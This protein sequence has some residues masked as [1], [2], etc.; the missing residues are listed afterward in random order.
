MSAVS[1]RARQTTL[2]IARF[3]RATGT[4]VPF[5]HPK[6]AFCIERSEQLFIRRLFAN[7]SY[8]VQMSD[9]LP[10]RNAVKRPLACSQFPCHG[11]ARAFAA[12][13]VAP[14]T[15]VLRFF[16]EEEKTKLVCTHGKRQ[17]RQR[18]I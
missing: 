15:K 13:I 10:T 14:K 18:V 6:L 11:V 7:A 9:K 3:L 12:E 5:F 8:L 2:Q 17:Q 1:L 4:A 16:P